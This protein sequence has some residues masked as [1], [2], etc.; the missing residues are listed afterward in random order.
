MNWIGSG[1]KVSCQTENSKCPELTKDFKHIDYLKSGN[2]R[3]KRA[4]T[5]I[6]KLNILELLKT[7]DP[8]LTGTIPIGIDLPD[9]DLD[10]ICQ[11]NNHCAF[12]VHMTKLF[13]HYDHFKIYT[14]TYQNIEST[15][16]EFKTEQFSFEIFGQNIP[17][18]QQNAYQHMVI[19]DRILTEKGSKFRQDIIELKSNG[20][21]T[22]PAFAK[23]LGLS[24]DPYVEL[25][26]L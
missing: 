4:Y 16:A 10:I 7:Y 15:I 11:C 19:E 5:V 12:S 1:N 9:S 2:N 25:L 22:E 24:G 17:T 6:K 8:I 21:K 26:K 20:M 3:Q 14:T 18:N 23:L 13:G